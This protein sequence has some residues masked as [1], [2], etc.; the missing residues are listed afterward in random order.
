MRSD[1]EFQQKLG[2]NF[3]LI[4]TQLNVRI[5]IAVGYTADPRLPDRTRMEKISNNFRFSFLTTAQI[6]T[7]ALMHHANAVA[8][9]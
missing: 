7:T 5:R 8:I 1:G 2:F 9:I 4:L 6:L 3:L